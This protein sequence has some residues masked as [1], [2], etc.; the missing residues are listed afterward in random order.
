MAAIKRATARRSSP[1]RVP[2][3]R[4]LRRMAH[5]L[6][7]EIIRLQYPVCTI[8]GKKPSAQAHHVLS[9]R[10]YGALRY[11]P[12]GGRGVCSRCHLAVH[13]SP[14]LQALAVTPEEARALFRLVEETERLPWTRSRLSLVIVGLQAMLGDLKAGK[15]AAS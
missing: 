6:W 9:Q 15:E 4:S 8:C 5:G 10:H 11:V 13:T 7:A 1:A 2:S 14:L 12:S 3:L